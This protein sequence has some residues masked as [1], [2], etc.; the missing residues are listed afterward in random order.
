MFDIVE[1]LPIITVLAIAVPC[2]VAVALFFL[3][4][5]NRKPK[6]DVQL[7]GID[8]RQDL[9]ENEANYFSYIKY[10]QGLNAIVLRQSQ[11]F[12]KCVVTLITKKEG[13]LSMKKYN[14]KYA[15][16]DLSCGIQLEGQIEE[17]RVVLESVDN[18]TQKHPSFDSALTNNILYAIIVSLLFVVGGGAYIVAC[19]FC[20]EDEWLGYSFYYVF[21]A[22]VLVYF[23]VIVGGFLLGESL[24]KKGK[25]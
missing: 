6:K 13:R 7:F 9:D 24:S 8:V 3:I 14:L 15:A 20:L 1:Y 22:L 18:N 4:V 12:N 21:L 10:D 5:L 25:F 2:V 19:S 17:Y 16:N 23:A 11:V